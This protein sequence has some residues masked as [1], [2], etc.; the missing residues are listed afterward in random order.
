MRVLVLGGAGFLG[1][2]VAAALAERGHR[3][4]IGSR[5]KAPRA[6]LADSPDREWRNVRFEAMTTPRQW[7]DAVRNVDA[8]VNC[9]GIL[10]EKGRATYECVHHRSPAALAEA[11]ARGGIRQ[12]I[13]VSALGL[14]DD[15]RSRFVGSKLRGERAIRA[16]GC[17]CTI[18]RPSLLDGEGGYGARWLRAVARLPIHIVPADAQGRIAAVDVRDV[19][20]AIAVLCEDAATA[21]R[22]VE[23]GGSLTRTLR[24][25]LAA[26]RRVHAA[27]PPRCLRLP[28]PLAR[29]ASHLCDVL[30]V[31][32]FSFGHLELLRRDNRPAVN[33]LPALLGR[34]PRPV[35]V[36]TD[37]LPPPRAHE[38]AA[39]VAGGSVNRA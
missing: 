36:A 25:L 15:A 31:S 17:A 3:V 12:F 23:L 22:D 35:G 34:A 16:A 19:G 9:V 2:H 14:H 38:E 5:R 27:A 7:D 4:V 8:V 10:R 21:S 32:P 30:H 1:R 18:V 13:H 20:E 6:P 39:V 24:E 29:L 26:L 33:L 28:A 37:E 11:C